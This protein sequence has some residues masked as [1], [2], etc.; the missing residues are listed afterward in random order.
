M[1]T[2][3]V[4]T[5]RMEAQKTHKM[6]CAVAICPSP[7]N[8]EIKYHRFPKDETTLKK[9]VVAC[10]R[11]DFFNAK[12]SFVC[13]NHFT[14]LDYKRDLKHELQGL[15]AKR[16]LREGVVPTQNLKHEVSPIT[17]YSRHVGIQ[18]E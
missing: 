17:T 18:L 10:K 4:E 3:E 8:N 15:P 14:P 2:I 16:H 7:K 6:V 12:K 5:F 1:V 9:W 13:S 11:E